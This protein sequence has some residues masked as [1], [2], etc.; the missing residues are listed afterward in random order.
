MSIDLLV[1]FAVD[2]LPGSTISPP[3]ERISKLC[4]RTLKP[5]L[6]ASSTNAR[7]IVDY[8][9]FDCWLLRYYPK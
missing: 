6:H 5:C 8:L 3:R 1:S 2:L 9:I 7:R 4:P